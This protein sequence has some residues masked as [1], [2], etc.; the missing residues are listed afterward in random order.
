MDMFDEEL[1]LPPFEFGEAF[2]P[3]PGPPTNMPAALPQFGPP[4]Q[5]P[6]GGPPARFRPPPVEQGQPMVPMLA[7]PL[8]A[9]PTG[10]MGQ[11]LPSAPAPAVALENGHTLGLT[12]LLV[13]IGSA[14]GLTYGGLFGGVAGGL[15][16]GSMVNL[17]RAYRHVVRGTPEDDREAT[18]SGTY[19]VLGGAV[20]LYLFYKARSL[21]APN[22][23]KASMDEGLSRRL[24]G[25]R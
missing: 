5:M 2:A 17:W 24:R 10:A 13:G 15:A 12:V 14:A 4:S 3:V 7:P 25:V 20:S 23:P 21:S 8:P 18:I 1:P 22:E 19:G 9:F 6:Q 16:G 11:P